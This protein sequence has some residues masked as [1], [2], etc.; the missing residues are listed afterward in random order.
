M[1]LNGKQLSALVKMGVAMALADGKV[2]E[3][4]KAA[5]AIELVKFGVTSNQATQIINNSQSMDASDAL[6]TLA[7]MNTEQKKYATG[8]LAAVMASDGDIDPS[9]IKMWQLICT[10]SAFPTMNIGE[11][12]SFWKEH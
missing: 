6:E 2:E 1:T 9:E 12:L 3:T 5:I 11:A 8:Y 4:E 7:W 10:L